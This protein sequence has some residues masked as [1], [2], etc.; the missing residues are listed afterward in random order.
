M[1][2]VKNATIS[3]CNFLILPCECRLQPQSQKRLSLSTKKSPAEDALPA[4][5]KQIQPA[6]VDNG[7]HF[8]YQQGVHS[9]Q[10]HHQLVRWYNCHGQ[11]QTATYNMLCWEGYQLQS[12]ISPGPKQLQVPKTWIQYLGWP[13]PLWT[14]T[15]RHSS[16]KILY[17]LFRINYICN[18][19]LKSFLFVFCIFLHV[20]SLDT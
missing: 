17:K 1:H 5:I 18:H 2:L 10:H 11:G 8:H 7:G 20:C 14:Q 9:H 6:S 16:L 12:A 19:V 13:F 15:F 4:A 3:C